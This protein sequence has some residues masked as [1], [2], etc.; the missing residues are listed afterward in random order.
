MELLQICQGFHQTLLSLPCCP[1]IPLTA[2]KGSS[3]Q[4]ITGE[5]F[6]EYSEGSKEIS[7]S[8]KV[9]HPNCPEQ[10]REKFPSTEQLHLPVRWTLITFQ[11]ILVAPGA[12]DRG[13]VDQGQPWGS[14]SQG[15]E[16]RSE[17]GEPRLPSQRQALRVEEKRFF[18]L[19]FRR[20]TGIPPPHG[21][22]IVMLPSCPHLGK[23]EGVGTARGQ[24]MRL[25]LGKPPS[26]S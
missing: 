23:S 25:T 13:E 18:S 2:A 3:K 26:W 9:L 22:S 6:Q 15:W 8:H 10:H 16:R 7:F 21:H 11:S 4:A 1:L 5:V 17:M 24:G 12:C 14:T 20:T 19:F